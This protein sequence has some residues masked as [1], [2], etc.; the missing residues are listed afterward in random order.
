MTALTPDSIEIDGERFGL[1]S[2]PLQP[3][4][5]AHRLSFEA[6]STACM[7]GYHASWRLSEDRL[8][9]LD[10]IGGLS[11]APDGSPFLSCS[12]RRIRRT[13]VTLPDLF[14]AVGGRPVL[15]EWFSGRLRLPSGKRLHHSNI[16]APDVYE[17]VR[18][19]TLHHGVVVEERIHDSR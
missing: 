16:D 18:I 9:L 12:G 11:K 13:T 17:R 8:W 3:W 5:Q 6:A 2:E 14:P 1:F 4:L 7:R 15:A 19:V 10:L